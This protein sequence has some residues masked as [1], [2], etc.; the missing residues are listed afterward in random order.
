MIEKISLKNFKSHADTTIELGRVTALVGPNGCGKTSVLQAAHYW[1]R[2]GHQVVNGAQLDPTNLRGYQRRG[3]TNISISINGNPD[4]WETAISLGTSDE[5]EE[6]WKIGGILWRGRSG[7]RYL[8]DSHAPAQITLRTKPI[9]KQVCALFGQVVYFK[10]NAENIASPS[11]KLNIPPVI[12]IDGDGLAS[13]IGYLKTSQEETH[14]GIEQDLKK[15]VRLIKRIRVR[16]VS[17]TIKEKRTISA[18]GNTLTYDEDRHVIA[19]ELIFDTSSGDTLPAS[20]MSEG[21]LI[22]LAL[23]TLLHTT[24]A[25]L[26]LLDDI[27]AGLHPLAQHKLV[28]FLTKFAEEHQK[29]ILFTTHSPYILDDL[30]A[31]DV[32]VMATDQEGI[33]HCKRLSDHPHAEYA[34]KVLTTGELWDAE[35]EQWVTGETPAP[36]PAH[37]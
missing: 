7:S 26:F 5:A 6:L 27:E 3:Q 2:V 1:N 11:Y 8:P 36:E 37:A 31:K 20:M 23:L 34:L 17:K 29:Q 30:D 32:W 10:A 22:L 19:Q 28:Q 4:D 18:N 21:T 25:S 24:D 15:I 33:S 13:V 9:D 12:G 35:G 16:P 14:E